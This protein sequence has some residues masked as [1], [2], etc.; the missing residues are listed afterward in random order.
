V[1]GNAGAAGLAGACILIIGADAPTGLDAVGVAGTD[2][3][4][5]TGLD[6]V[7]V[8]VLTCDFDLLRRLYGGLTSGVNVSTGFLLVP[9]FVVVIGLAITLV[10]AFV[11]TGT[12]APVITCDLVY[13]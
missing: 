11:I 7:G 2:A 13:V 6:A 10:I 8:A 4:A 1:N 3:G 5:P 9:I 12:F